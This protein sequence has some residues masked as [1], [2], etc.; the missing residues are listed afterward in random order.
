MKR[1]I[2]SMLLAV[3]VLLTTIDMSA[4]AAEVREQATDEVM[5]EEAESV[6][7]DFVAYSESEDFLTALG[8]A[9]VTRA[10]W[11][12]SLAETFEMTVE[13]D[14]FEVESESKDVT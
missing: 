1:R 14:T 9:D 13:E 2:F 12:F 3:I 6:S 11:L 10:E 4:F 7:E 5:E 8:E